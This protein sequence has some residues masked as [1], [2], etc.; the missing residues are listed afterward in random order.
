MK[1]TIPTIIVGSLIA[2]MFVA[3]RMKSF[4]N[5]KTSYQKKSTTDEGGSSWKRQTGHNPQSYRDRKFENAPNVV[6]FPSQVKSAIEILSLPTTSVPS[7]EAV[8][9]AFR[10]M[11]MENHPDR[12]V[13]GDSDIKREAERNFRAA[14]DAKDA[15]L[16]Y[17]GNKS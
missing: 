17:L 3:K 16:E 8:K 10:R 7:E 15:I 2:N 9:I 1:Y 14:K 5:V 6:M 11:A 4:M 12:L 13:S